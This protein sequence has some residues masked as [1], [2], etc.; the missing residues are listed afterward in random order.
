M[1]LPISPLFLR[2]A[3]RCSA[4]ELLGQFRVDRRVAQELSLRLQVG[5]CFRQPEI[6]LSHDSQCVAL[7]RHRANPLAPSDEK[8]G[9]A[10]EFV[11]FRTLKSMHCPI[12]DTA[13]STTN[14]TTAGASDTVRSLLNG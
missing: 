2:R 5:G 11:Q 4:D 7:T 1:A 10:P 13:F 3:R 14:A 8:V 9:C 12:V 6:F